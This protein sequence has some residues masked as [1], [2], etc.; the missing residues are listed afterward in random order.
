MYSNFKLA[1]SVLYRVLSLTVRM[2]NVYV[3]GINKRHCFK[4]TNWN[5]SM[6]SA[7]FLYEYNADNFRTCIDSVVTNAHIAIAQITYSR[8]FWPATWFLVLRSWKPIFVK[9]KPSSNIS[10]V[11]ISIIFFD[12]PLLNSYFV[13][14]LMI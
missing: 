11:C 7:F 3:K 13:A 12:Y 4:L 1:R 9:L 8:Q 14:H 2:L 5:F 6:N 10:D